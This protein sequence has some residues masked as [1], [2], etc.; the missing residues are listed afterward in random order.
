MATGEII[1]TG[2]CPP[3]FVELQQR[4]GCQVFQGV[5]DPATQ[6]RSLATG[7]L[8]TKD[9]MPVTV[10]KS[11]IVAD[12][13]DAA[14]LDNV[15]AGTRVLIGGDMQV[16]DDGIVEFT[17]TGPGQYAIALYHAHYLTLE[18]QVTAT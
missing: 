4:E 7:A 18:V 9:P 3:Q 6:Y 11:S 14:V 1:Q 10:I 16:C 8:M 12:G 2:V 13:E 5:A 17:T 15:P